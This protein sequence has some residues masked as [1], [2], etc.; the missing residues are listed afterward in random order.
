VALAFAGQKLE[1]TVGEAGE[2]ASELEK[3]GHKHVVC[4]A[5][6]CHVDR[7]NRVV[8]TPAY[9]YDDANLADIFSGIQK[10]V[11]EV[12]GMA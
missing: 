3:L 2:A 1:L 7:A 9:M 6:G 8:T 10:L 5:N 11:G 4:P 12:V